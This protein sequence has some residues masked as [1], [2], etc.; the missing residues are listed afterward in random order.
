MLAHYDLQSELVVDDFLAPEDPRIMSEGNRCSLNK[1]G[2]SGTKEQT[3]R[4][5]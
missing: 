5:I 2:S 1:Y 3:R 4:S